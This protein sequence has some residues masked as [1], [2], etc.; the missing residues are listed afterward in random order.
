MT[1][2]FPSW[3]WSSAAPLPLHALR[4]RLQ[5]ERQLGIEVCQDR[6]LRQPPLQL[7]EGCPLV[8]APDPLG[9]LPCQPVQRFGHARKLLDELAHVVA[10]GDK[11]PHLRHQ[12]WLRHL[13]DG[14]DAV[15]IHPHAAR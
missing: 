4:V 5:D 11:P 14:L 2:F 8:R 7:C 10:H 6:R 13:R 3:T 9:A 1:R 15:R 12:L